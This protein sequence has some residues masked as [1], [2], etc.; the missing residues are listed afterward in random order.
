MAGFFSRLLGQSRQTAKLT[1]AAI[2]PRINVYQA[3][4]IIATATCC[5]A[6]AETRGQRFL[7]RQAPRLP[8]AQCDR[9]KDCACRFQKYDDRRDGSRRTLYLSSLVKSYPGREKRQ[10]QSRRKSDR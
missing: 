7:A 4:S 2:T 9:P 8:L 10:V 1:P 3:V 5:A 6:A